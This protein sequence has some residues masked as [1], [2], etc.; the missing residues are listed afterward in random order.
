VRTIM[1][2]ND[3]MG[4]PSTF[5]LMYTTTKFHDA[6]PKV[7]AAFLAAFEE[8]IAMINADKRAAAASFLA[9]EPQA[10]MTV[11]EVVEVL[12][13]PDIRYTTSPENL[14]KYADFMAGVGTLKQKP[15]SW[16][17]LFFPAI[18]GRPGG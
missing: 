17:E 13:D 7:Y 11:D 4:G 3:V 5:T 18:H 10:G 12:S 9:M 16:Q 2:S 6:N 14:L 1:T 8:A 15:A